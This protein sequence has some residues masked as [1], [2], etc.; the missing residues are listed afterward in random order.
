MR[1]VP[2]SPS[3]QVA[4]RP[5]RKARHVCHTLDSFWRTG[6][7]AWPRGSKELAGA[8]REEQE[9]GEGGTGTAAGGW[10]QREGL[11]LQGPSTSGERVERKRSQWR[12]DTHRVSG[13]R[14]VRRAVLGRWEGMARS[15]CS[16]GLL[17][18]RHPGRAQPLVPQGLRSG[19]GEGAHACPKP[20]IPE[21]QGLGGGRA[22][23]G[24]SGAGRRPAPPQPGLR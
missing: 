16:S 3:L 13:H 7:R 12:E 8:K 14:S 17:P 20:G 18:S 21:W 1:G 23:R 11:S 2:G 4:V 15:P 5:H 10:G 9:E 24:V 19:A 22:A 6:L